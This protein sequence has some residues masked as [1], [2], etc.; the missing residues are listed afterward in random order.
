ML[1][2]IVRF[3]FLHLMQKDAREMKHGIGLH[4]RHKVAKVLYYTCGILLVPMLF[5]LAFLLGYSLLGVKNIQPT[6]V[7]NILLVDVVLISYSIGVTAA[8]IGKVL[9]EKSSK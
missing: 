7:Y 5:M 8:Y 1:I 6:N 9:D 3:P 4:S 2:Q